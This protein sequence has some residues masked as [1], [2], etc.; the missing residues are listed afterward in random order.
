MDTFQFSKLF[1]RYP[2]L[3]ECETSISQSLALLAQCFNSGGKL[4]IAGN[5]G[6]SADAEHFCGELGKGFLSKRELTQEQK[7]NYSK[8]DRDL[9]ENLQN[10]LPCFSLG[11]SHSLISAFMN[12]MDP[13]YVYAQQVHVHL[14]QNDCLFAISTSG[15]S[16]N[17]VEAIKVAK[18][19][20]AITIGL[21]GEKESKISSLADVTIKAPGTVTHEVQELHLPIYHALCIELENYFYINN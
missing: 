7:D 3:R 19:K 10:G 2:I 5:G 11:V 9:A 14:N 12:D 15:N 1:Q 16:A 18:A 21:T 20:G 13:K 4:L 6:S 17:I 8:I